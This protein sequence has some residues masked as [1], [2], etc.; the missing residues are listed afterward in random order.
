VRKK[1]KTRE[2]DVATKS[3][4]REP[5]TIRL[6]RWAKRKASSCQCSLQ[7]RMRTTHHLSNSQGG[8]S[9]LTCPSFPWKGQ[10][11]AL[12][13]TAGGSPLVPCSFTVRAKV[14]AVLPVGDK[15]TQ[16]GPRL[17]CST[18]LAGGEES[19]SPAEGEEKKKDISG[20]SLRH[21]KL[22]W[23]GKKGQITLLGVAGGKKEG[24]K[25]KA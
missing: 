21:Q 14:G 10:P 3:K 19:L 12:R 24:G 23:W 17:P 16:P 1:K 7:G 5:D 20:S 4:K 6:L 11:S 8:K 13:K 9:I 25:R 2:S 22:E 15:G 18:L